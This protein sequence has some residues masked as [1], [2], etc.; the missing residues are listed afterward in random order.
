M[1]QDWR[2]RWGQ[3]LFPFLFVQLA[4]FKQVAREPQDSEWAELREA[5]TFALS[6][7]NNA[8]AVAIDIGDAADIH[9]KNKQE[10]AHRLAL[11]A[12]ARVYGEKIEYSGPAYRSGSMRVHKSEARLT[13]DHA[14]GGLVAK[15]D[16]GKLLGFTIAG[17]DRGFAPAEARID[18][19]T[20]IVR[21]DSVQRPVAVRYAWADN[22]TCNLYNA[23]GLP[24]PPF[25]TDEWPG[26]TGKP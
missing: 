21:S 2:Q 11:A 26:I 19:N 15:G 14:Q 18:D 17:D 8:M 12:L 10:I 7:P 25:R 3:G 5:Q 6:L 24:A 4:N 22:P 23:A 13:F 9:P 20:V 1:I 16:D